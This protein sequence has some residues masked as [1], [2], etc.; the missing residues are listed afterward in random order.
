M[1]SSAVLGWLCTLGFSNGFCFPPSGS[2]LPSPLTPC[3]QKPGSITLEVGKFCVA[4]TFWCAAVLHK[5]W[6]GWRSLELSNL[7]LHTMWFVSCVCVSEQLNVT[8]ST[9]ACFS[10]KDSLFF[11]PLH[12][13]FTALLDRALYWI[14]HVKCF[15]LLWCYLLCRAGSSTAHVLWEEQPSKSEELIVRGS[16]VI[17]WAELS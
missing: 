7:F 4:I 9:E 1:L 2:E 16:C 8:K 15:D 14:S 3:L 11:A 13:L 10:N 6:L 17:S 12:A 5:V